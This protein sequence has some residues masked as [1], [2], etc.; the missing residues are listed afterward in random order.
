MS[1]AR[2]RRSTVQKAVRA[3]QMRRAAGV[4]GFASSHTCAPALRAFAVDGRERL[5]VNSGAAG[6]PKLRG[7]RCGLVTRI[8]LS[9][10][11][12]GGPVSYGRALRRMHETVQVHAVALH[13]DSAAFERCLLALWPEGSDAHAPYYARIR[14]GPDFDLA[15]ALGSAALSH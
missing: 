14:R 4:D 11:P 8:A 1:P 6:M 3:T 2:R 7:E 9:P 15:Q 13:Y 12:A 5:I 10:P